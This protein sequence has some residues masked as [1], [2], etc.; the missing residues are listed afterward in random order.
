MLDGIRDSGIFDEDV[1]ISR[2]RTIVRTETSQAVNQA[3]LETYSRSS[4]NFVEWIAAG[5]AEID[6]SLLNGEVL[7]LARA[8]GEIP[9]H[10]NCRCN[11][12]P[13]L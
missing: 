5:D 9:L 8:Y 13:V 12:I 2:M 10:P 11:W 4:V 7:T 1:S 6:C 3:R